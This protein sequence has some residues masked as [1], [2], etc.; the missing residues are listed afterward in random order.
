MTPG[1][2]AA[3]ALLRPYVAMQRTYREAF[4]V[5]PPGRAEN[6]Y[7]AGYLAALNF[8]MNLTRSAAEIMADSKEDFFVLLMES[9]TDFDSREEVK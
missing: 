7:K 6:A 2:S 5:C 1:N 9:V 8:S 3:A 4:E